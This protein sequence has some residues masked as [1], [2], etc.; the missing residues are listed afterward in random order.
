MSFSNISE[1]ELA[2]IFVYSKKE[3]IEKLLG[4]NNL[5]AFAAT[6]IICNF[7]IKHNSDFLSNHS[8]KYNLLFDEMFFF[9]AI[10]ELEKI[11]NNG[12]DL[13]GGSSFYEP[14]VAYVS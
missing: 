2:K 7:I 14:N 12:A 13:D 10:N 4:I 5:D 8:N 3:K 11:K 9:A 6:E 1:I